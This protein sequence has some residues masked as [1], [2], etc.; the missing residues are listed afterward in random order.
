M[1]TIAK[2]L[3]HYA[4]E[5][6]YIIKSPYYWVDSNNHANL[7]HPI[8]GLVAVMSCG[9]KQDSNQHKWKDYKQMLRECANPDAETR[10][11]RGGKDRQAGVVADHKVS[12]KTTPPKRLSK[13]EKKK[14]SM[15]NKAKKYN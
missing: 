5:L 2:E 13:A 1:P 10:R 14:K 9:N 7:Q 6:G 15:E 12:A 4:L 11:F 3:K 8:T